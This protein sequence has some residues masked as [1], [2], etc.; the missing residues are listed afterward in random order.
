MVRIRDLTTV[1]KPLMDTSWKGSTMY[2]WLIPLRVDPFY[3][4][5]QRKANCQPAPDDGWRLMPET[6]VEIKAHIQTFVEQRK[7]EAKID[8][9]YDPV[10]KEWTCIVILLTDIPNLKFDELLSPSLDLDSVQF[11][12]IVEQRLNVYG[13]NPEF[14]TLTKG[15]WEEFACS[16]HQSQI[17]MNDCL[18]LER[19]GLVIPELQNDFVM[20]GPYYDHTTD[21]W[22]SNK[23]SIW[24]CF[25]HPYLRSFLRSPNESRPDS[26]MNYPVFYWNS[27]AVQQ[28]ISATIDPKTQQNWNKGKSEVGTGFLYDLPEKISTAEVTTAQGTIGP[29]IN[30]FVPD[31]K[32]S[33]WYLT[34]AHCFEN[35][36]GSSLY[37]KNAD[38]K[39][40][41][42]LIAVNK[43]LDVAVIEMWET[44]DTVK[45]NRTSVHL[46]SCRT[47]HTVCTQFLDSTVFKSGMKTQ[48]T[49]GRIISFG[50]F[51]RN[52]QGSKHDLFA[53]VLG[54][55]DCFSENGDSGS[56]VAVWNG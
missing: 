13:S 9:L 47:T 38:N 25:D 50:G 56:V 12:I 1:V 32:I 29:R 11:S 33:S 36:N 18:E 17:C 49:T 44:K 5:L 37:L 24:I 23:V 51:A 4:L 20:F 55:S 30:L 26:F 31:T 54:D 35:V 15:I 28:S 53:V 27:F 48:G 42:R 7:I 2:P 19:M 14:E 45:T 46:A 43:D 22:I 16:L 41:G 21:S 6:L 52:L 34:C 40:I 10:V 39:K 3:L 8:L